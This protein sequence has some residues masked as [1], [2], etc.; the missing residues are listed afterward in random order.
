M[1]PN[2]NYY[3]LYPNNTQ[4]TTTPQEITVQNY[5]YTYII[6]KICQQTNLQ[7]T[8]THAFGKQ[9]AHNIINIAAYIIQEGNTL[10][11]IDD[12]QQK[13]YLPNQTTPLTSQTTSKLFTNQTENQRNKFFTN[14]IKTTLRECY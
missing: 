4:T 10:D 1:H 7:T 2:N 14:W 11:G 9:H 6:N 13:T 5:G 3:D 12:W 8:L